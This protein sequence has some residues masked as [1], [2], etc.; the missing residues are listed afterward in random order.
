MFVSTRRTVLKLGAS[1]PL[2]GA[3]PALAADVGIRGGGS[4]FVSPVMGRWTE[5]AGKRGMDVSYSVLGTGI[6]QNQ[7][8]AAEIDY[9]AVELP[10]AAD[11]LAM[12][13]LIQFPVVFGAI[14]IVVNIAGIADGQLKLNANLLGGIYGGTIKNWNDPRIAE[15]N[16]GLHLPDTEVH[17]VFLGDPAGSLF[18]TSTT[19]ARYLIANNADWQQRFA[20]GLRA[21]WATGTMVPTAAA[22][23]PVMQSRPGGIG[24]MA[25]GTAL[26]GKLTRATIQNKN[27]EAALPSADSLKA[28][29][30]KIDWAASPDLV[31]N[32][33]D[34][35]GAGVWPLV[36]PTYITIAGNPKNPERAA[37]VRA[38][39]TFVVNEGGDQV[40]TSHA[41]PLPPEVRVKVLAML[42]AG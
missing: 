6:A 4:S 20:G 2:V 33:V 10:I 26:S 31:V 40:A 30:S 39:F 34:R 1:V 24:Y 38:F 36:L 5:A 28:A 19:L 11:R 29:V 23:V 42:G 18:S 32:A 9:G 37:A 3:M 35:P 25:L 7:I 16:P 13:S 41:E 12:S 8:L 17:P 21:R 27:G 14:A 22:M 15:A